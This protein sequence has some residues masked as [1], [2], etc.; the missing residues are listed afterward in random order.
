MRF[1]RLFLLIAVVSLAGAPALAHE[2]G[3]HAKGTVKEMSAERIVLVTT[4]GTELSLAIVSGT[5]ITRGRRTIQAS[6]VRPGERAVVHS[7]KR[8]ERLEATVVMV[9]EQK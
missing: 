1:V 8:G 4:S 9:A 3:T 2:G 6:D 5:Q 7:A